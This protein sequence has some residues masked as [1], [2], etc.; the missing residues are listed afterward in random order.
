MYNFQGERYHQNTN[1][2][3]NAKPSPLNWKKKDLYLSSGEYEPYNINIPKI[4]LNQKLPYLY[5]N[6]GNGMINPLFNS[7]QLSNN[8]NQ[9]NYNNF[10]PYYQSPKLVMGLPLIIHQA[11]KYKIKNKNFIP[12][13]NK[14]NLQKIRLKKNVSNLVTSNI[15]QETINTPQR[16]ISPDYESKLD[17]L[18]KRK[19]ERKMDKRLFFGKIIK[20]N[21]T[22]DNI[23]RGIKPFHITKIRDNPFKKWWSL[24]RYFVKIYYF[25]S[26]SKVYT[27]KIKLIREKEIIPI[28]NNLV[29]EIYILRNWIL[30]LEGTYWTD[31]IKYKDVNTSF[32]E[33]DSFNKIKENS[34]TLLLLIDDYLYNLRIG[35][36]K[37]EQ[38]PEEVQKIIYRFIRKNTY[39][40]S[41]YLNLFH[42]KRLNFD[43]YGRCLNNT[44]EQ[45]GMLLCYLLISSI[46]VQQI[47]LNIKFIFKKLKP[48]D[49]IS[50]TCKYVASILYYLEREAYINKTKI[51]NDYLSLFNYYRSY[52][53]S[54][55]IIEKENNTNILLGVNESMNFVK[56]KEDTNNDIYNKLL[57]DDKTIDKFWEVNSKIMKGFS[58]SLYIWSTNLAKLILKKLET[59]KN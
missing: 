10:S 56:Y 34:R 28:E 12:A 30:E 46:S 18:P 26:I 22:E 3:Y 11:K 19:G 42:I 5:S 43:F 38:I 48:Y 59:K 25:F 40:P 7:Y 13:L 39:F 14:T 44:S 41:K 47:L 23:E 29:N 55:S 53:L 49:N 57:I 21:K 51:S 36:I 6:S 4:T 37:I 15:I 54:S 52:H 33:F 31:L 8:L 45:S 32:N 58:N 24:L 2:I 1:N 9:N 35:T 17:E 20:R 27:K 16:I 50:I